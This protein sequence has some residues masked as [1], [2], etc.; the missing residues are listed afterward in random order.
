[1]KNIKTNTLVDSAIMVAV[2]A[3][4]ILMSLWIP[5]F[6][7]IGMFISGVPLAVVTVKH[8]LKVSALS[9]LALLLILCIVLSDPLGTCS[10]FLLIV[11]PGIMSGICI[12][13]DRSFFT[14]LILVILAVVLSV[15][16]N[17]QI[18]NITLGDDAITSMITQFSEAF[19]QTLKERFNAIDAGQIQGFD[20]EVMVNGIKDT[21]FNAMTLY[22]PTLVV[23]TSM[24]IGYISFKINIY[25]VRRLNIKDYKRTVPFEYFKATKGM[26]YIIFLI[27]ILS[28]FSGGNNSNSIFMS[29]LSNMDAIINFIV[30]I[31][32]LSVIDF[33]F[34]KA[35]VKS[36]LR[37][38]IYLAVFIFGGMIM[39]ILS[40]VI[41]LIGTFDAFFN[42][43]RI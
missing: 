2:S 34:K 29:A 32:G 40:Y 20:I 23:V 11:L 15:L 30:F 38:I 43:R 18:L 33:Y 31:C 21:V 17:I 13:Y 27:Y 28:F 12:K 14:S 42:I 4:L 35:V 10:M 1:M 41:M 37:Y 9:S 16:A 3:S 39:T 5:F 25:F 19:S 6:S 26:L 7:I 8:G 24:I 36:G 22:F